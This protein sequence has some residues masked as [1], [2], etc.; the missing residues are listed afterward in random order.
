MNIFVNKRI[1]FTIASLL[2]M[3]LFVSA[4]TAAPNPISPDQPNEKMVAQLEPLKTPEETTATESPTQVSDASSNASQSI[5]SSSVTPRPRAQSQVSVSRGTVSEKSSGPS[6]SQKAT[7]IIATAKKYIGIKYVWGGTTPSG[8]DCSGFTQYV[9]AQHG[10]TLPRVS[11]DQYNT[12]RGVSLN[13]L[14]PGDLI[15]FSL[16][17]DKVIDHVGIYTGNGQFIN[18]SSSKGVTIYSLGSYWNS[19]FIGATRVL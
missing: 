14:Q 5:S 2:S 19:H 17:E 10:I 7:A 1:N 18:A 13:S 12:G 15:F 4:L 9:F 8:F 11:R 3:G 16:D 6:S